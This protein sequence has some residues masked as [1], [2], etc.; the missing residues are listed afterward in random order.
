MTSRFRDIENNVDA[1]FSHKKRGFLSETAPE[2]AQ[3]P[4]AQRHTLIQEATAE[5]MRRDTHK[6]EV[7]SH[8]KS[9]R[10]HFHHHTEGQ[11]EQ[12]RQSQAELRQILER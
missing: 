10:H 7:L 2:S 8:V 12:F 11:S 9:D 4:E 1:S 5:M 6:E 3:V